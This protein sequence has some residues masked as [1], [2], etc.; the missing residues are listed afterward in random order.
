[1]CQ[2]GERKLRERK[3]KLQKRKWKLWKRICKFRSAIEIWE[4]VSKTCSVLKTK[5]KNLPAIYSFSV[6][7][8]IY[9]VSIYIFISFLK[10]YVHFYWH[11]NSSICMPVRNFVRLGPAPTP[12]DCDVCHQST[13]RATREQP[14]T[15]HDNDHVCFVFIRTPLVPLKLT[16]QFCITVNTP[17]M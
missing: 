15:P 3:R 1:M 12:R 6:S 5:S 4:I 2:N 13:A 9:L 16:N 7:E 10:S 17:F 8:I 14:D 11:K